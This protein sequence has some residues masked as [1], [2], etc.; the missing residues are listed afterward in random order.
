MIDA[1]R[2]WFGRTDVQ[3]LPRATAGREVSFAEG[4]SLLELERAGISEDQAISVGLP[5]D[6]ARLSAIGANVMQLQKL[7][8]VRGWR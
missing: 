7:R 8:R 5:I 1:L 4:Y 2:R 6:R 3:L